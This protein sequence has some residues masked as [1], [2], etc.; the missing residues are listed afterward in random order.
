MTNASLAAL[1]DKPFGEAWMVAYFQMADRLDP[2]EFVTWYTPDGVFQAGNQ[3]PV[4][5]HD[6]I[7]AA[8]TPFYALIRTMRHEKTGCWIAGDSGVFEA[9]AHFETR[10]GRKLA[11]PAMTSLRVRDNRVARLLF[12]MDPSPIFHPDMGAAQ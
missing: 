5:G 9:V 6:A 7:I 3:P 12:V 10:D 8:L 4:T 1:K 2:Q 11:L